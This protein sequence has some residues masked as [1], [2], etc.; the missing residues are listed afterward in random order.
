M[1]TVIDE[2]KAMAMLSHPFILK[3][4][5]WCKEPNAVVYECARKGNVVTAYGS[6]GFSFPHALKMCE[7]VANAVVYL[8][9]WSPR[10]IV[11]GCLLPKNVLVTE[12]W[13]AK[14]V[15]CGKSLRSDF[16]DYLSSTIARDGVLDSAVPYTAPE[17]LAAEQPLCT[18]ASDVFS[19]GVLVI[20]ILNGQMPYKSA[21]EAG[22]AF[23]E[24]KQKIVGG[25]LSAMTEIKSSWGPGLSSALT[26][27][28][29]REP[30]K[31]TDAGVVCH[32]LHLVM[33][34]MES[35]DSKLLAADI[36][37]TEQQELVEETIEDTLALWGRIRI[38]PEQIKKGR[39]LGVGGFADVYSW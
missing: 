30:E 39:K 31:R 17:V 27:A 14:L 28:L 16:Q 9:S 25:D 38:K 32:A 13:H 23:E 10:A 3:M 12:R 15:K 36:K 24:L 33:Q 1:T 19:L 20:E 29:D 26:S 22:I 21:M 2:I 4:Y 37:E 35:L 18:T 11:H 6:D 34:Q 8:H 5:A 7:H